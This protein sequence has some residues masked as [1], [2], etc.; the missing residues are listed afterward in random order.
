[1]KGAAKRALWWAAAAIAWLSWGLLGW[2]QALPTMLIYHLAFC[3]PARR[4]VRPLPA[5]PRSLPGWAAPAACLGAMAAVS[6]I[7]LAAGAA[8]PT[9]TQ[10]LAYLA[11]VGV[12][13]GAVAFTVGWLV[14]VNPF[15]EELAWRGAVLPALSRRWGPAR[16]EVAQAALFGS[17]HGLTG[18]LLL[19]PGF[20]LPSALLAG[21]GGWALARVA[22]WE[23]GV[24]LAA[25]LHLGAD[26]AL[27][28]VAASA[29][30]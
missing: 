30:L 20:A 8:L 9:G 5:I 19:G 15:M 29:L 26:L 14:L 21:L 24:R 28:A 17:Y 1:M 11:A 4:L 2:R 10:N 16:G 13:G 23:G 3:L 27:G 7:A 22:R 6:L 12:S 25:A 18:H